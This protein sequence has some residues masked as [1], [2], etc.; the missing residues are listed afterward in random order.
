[1]VGPPSGLDGEMK[2]GV[3]GREGEL[4]AEEGGMHG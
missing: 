1:M 3:K 4:M 2:I